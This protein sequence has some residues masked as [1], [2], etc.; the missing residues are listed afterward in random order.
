MDGQILPRDT[1]RA[2]AV[3]SANSGQHIGITNPYP[4]GTAAHALWELSYRLAVDE[5]EV[6]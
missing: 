1:I 6:V 4:S 5:L 2:Q 3:T